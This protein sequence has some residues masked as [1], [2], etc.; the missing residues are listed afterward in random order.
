MATAGN[1]QQDAG[2][3]YF[4]GPFDTSTGAGKAPRGANVSG[5]YADLRVVL[6]DANGNALLT[7][8]NPG[9]VQVA[10][11][12]DAALGATTDNDT[13]NTVIGRLKKLVS[14]LAGGLPS[15]LTALGNLKVAVQE[16]LPTGSN[17]IGTVGIDQTTPGT[18]NLVNAQGQ[19][20]HDAPASGNPLLTGGTYV[21]A[22]AAVNANDAANLNVDRYGRPRLSAGEDVNDPA[23]DQRSGA[24]AEGAT[25]TV[26]DTTVPVVLENVFWSV[27]NA[28]YPE[29]RIYRYDSAGNLRKLLTYSEAGGAIGQG[30]GFST[31]ANTGG[32][33]VLWPFQVIRNDAAGGVRSVGFAPGVEIKCPFG[34]K[35]QAFINAGG[36]A[37]SI[38]VACVYRKV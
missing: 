23:T 13:A 8:A 18:T 22:P 37:H 14:L 1:L 11:G 20:A 25:A 21:A 4:L 28:N 32:T 24:L 31:I 16:P 29:I 30:I 10:D 26:L 17:V 36:G 38:A 35:V 15:A 5:E 27:S 33:N 6:Y 2:G 34:I 9:Y 7:A 3:R 12:D 19:A